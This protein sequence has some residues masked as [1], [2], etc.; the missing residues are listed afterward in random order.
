MVDLRVLNAPGVETKHLLFPIKTADDAVS[1]ARYARRLSDEGIPVSVAL[2]HVTEPERAESP[3]C[4]L[5]NDDP[6]EEIWA[7]ASMMETA[8]RLLNERRLPHSSHILSGDVV[9]SILDA[10]ALLESE[11]IVLPAAKRR[12]PLWPF[13]GGV[14][15]KIRQSARDVSVVTVDPGG[16][17]QSRD[18]QRGEAGRHSRNGRKP[19]SVTLRACLSNTRSGFPYVKEWMKIAVRSSV[20][21]RQT[22]RWL[23]LLN[24]NPF[25]REW[26]RV[27]PSLIHK[28]Y[29]PYLTNAMRC[30]ERLKAFMEHYDFVFAQGLAPLVTRAARSPVPLATFCG[31]SG[32]SYTIRL[33]AIGTFDR[34]GELVL[35][36]MAQERLICSV[37]FF[38]FDSGHRPA[39]GIG[40]LQG[41][42]AGEGL[43]WIRRA[44]RDLHGLRPKSLMVSVV[45][46]LGQDYGRK[47]LILVGNRNRVMR[48]AIRKGILFAD[49]DQLWREMGATPRDDGDFQ[50]SCEIIPSGNIEA[51]P[52]RKRSEARKRQELV[53]QISLMLY[54]GCRS[55]IPV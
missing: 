52:S 30:H 20:H 39:I 3:A 41:P 42:Q 45:R 49:Y 7:E 1:S 54:D 11:E 9:P 35:Q 26:V 10:A 29:R 15:R 34:E 5:R 37:A 17:V 28:I 8:S 18:V 53:R 55:V 48:C 27:C 23:L 19:P 13:A 21:Y 31:K 2:L 38:F 22:R 25:F 12:V 43:A 14:I 40:C 50:L 44:T 4:F 32:E 24:S 6:L 51:I 46:Q 36:L 33:R 47:D 16:Y